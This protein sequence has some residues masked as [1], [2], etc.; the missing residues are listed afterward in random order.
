MR[1]S[2]ITPDGAVVVGVDGSD[3]ANEALR[4]AAA[5]AFP[6]DCPLHLMYAANPLAGFYGSGLP[7]PQSAYDD[8][9][10]AGNG[11]LQAAVTAACGGGPRPCGDRGKVVEAGSG[12]NR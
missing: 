6:G 7:M 10:R 4:W 8:L 2:D 12:A 9:D 5:E 1:A 11:L 3:K